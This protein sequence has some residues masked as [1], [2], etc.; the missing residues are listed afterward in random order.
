MM[1]VQEVTD[2]LFAVDATVKLYDI[3]ST[4]LLK[5]PNQQETTYPAVPYYRSIL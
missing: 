2:V 1:A 3:Y 5:N 4:N